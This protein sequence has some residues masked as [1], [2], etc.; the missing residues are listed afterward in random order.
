MKV[1]GC[2]ILTAWGMVA[3]G[4]VV[5][6][7]KAISVADGFT[8]ELAAGPDLAPYGCLLYTSDAADE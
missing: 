3:E 4:A 7:L 5:R 8:V 2:I 1:I 6:G